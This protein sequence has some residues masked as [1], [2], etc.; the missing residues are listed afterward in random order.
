MSIKYK[1]LSGALLVIGY[2]LSS[3]TYAA[4]TINNSM[5]TQDVNM[6]LGRITVRPSDAVGS[7]LLTRKFPI[8]RM[9]DVVN[10]GQGAAGTTTSAIVQ[11][12]PLSSVGN[13]VYQTNIEGIGIRLYRE[14]STESGAS[15]SGYYPY[16]SN[17]VSNLNYSLGQGNFVVE[18][19]KTGN[20][21]GSG[22]LLP[23]RYSSYHLTDNPG[24]PVL[25][26]TV[27][28]DTITIVSASC[29]IR[30]QTNQSVQLP[31]VNKADFKGVGTT[32]GERP[33][34]L[35]I[36]CSGGKNGGGVENN[37]I[38]LSFDYNLAA[39]TTNVLN[40]EAAASDKANGVGVQLVS[41]YQNANRVV[42][43]GEKVDLGV[44]GVNSN[45]EYN[46]PMVARYYQTAPSV[47]AGKVTSVS[48]VTINY[49]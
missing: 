22:A 46:I 33:F 41:N 13:S 8:N 32:Y 26:S 28:G 45:T 14:V 11:N 19:I 25:T 49:D 15:F 42:V 48:T 18:I 30:G 40:N 37:R 31:T 12:Y 6:A 35:N 36:L 2:A 34:D 24:K 16:V 47:S 3:E 20:I 5:V 21:T 17:L 27:Y 4:C 38:S 43:K 7:I 39:N 10:C 29:E 44:V 23:G 1:L 9:Q